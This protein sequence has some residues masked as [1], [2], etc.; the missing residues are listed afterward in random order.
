MLGWNLQPLESPDP[1]DALVVDDPAGRCPQQFRDLAVA[2]TAVLA[3]EFND[4]GRQA[5]FVVSPLGRL[6]LRRAVLSE[7]G[8]GT[9]L[10]Y[11]EFPPNVLDDGAAAGGADQF[12]LAASAR[13]SLSSVK[14]E[15]A[16]RS[17]AFS[18]SSSFRRLT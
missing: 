2:V 9:A 1:L 10:G 6:A 7:C 5:L 12:P 11:L 8:A 18:C 14:S 16:R 15:T 17:R 4:V 3:G 13:I